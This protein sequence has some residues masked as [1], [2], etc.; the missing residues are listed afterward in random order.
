MD[1]IKAR[2]DKIADTFQII[3]TT[4]DNAIVFPSIAEW[5]LNNKITL[6][7]YYNGIGR[8]VFSEPITNIPVSFLM[9]CKN[10][11]SVIIPSTCRVIHNYAFYGCENLEKVKFN[12][13][14]R[15][16]GEK[17]F[18]KTGFKRVEIPTT[19]LFIDDNAFDDSKLK[20]MKLKTPTTA[21]RYFGV[22]AIGKQIKV[23]G[24]SKYDDFHSTTFG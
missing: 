15:I 12:N 8:M 7:A 13:G 16:I 1:D 23:D 19:C 6:N 22:Y 9:G 14:L 21:Y 20:Y 11:T 10:L 3:Y 17:A 24:V 4:N 2:L 5:E 18:G